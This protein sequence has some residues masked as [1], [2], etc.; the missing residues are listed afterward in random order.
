MNF[1]PGLNAITGESGSGKSVLIEALSQLLGAP[2]PSEC[3]RSPATSA[4]IEGVIR[5]SPGDARQVAAMAASLG[6]PPKALP[7]AG[8][9]GP[10]TLVIRREV[11][12]ATLL[13]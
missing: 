9:Q 4:V 11:R 5:L 2:A 1:S 12:G 10:G 7:G 6:L 3:V 13:G 8:Q